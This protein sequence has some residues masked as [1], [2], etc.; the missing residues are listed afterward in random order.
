MKKMSRV[1]KFLFILNF[2]VACLLLL[3]GA[4]VFFSSQV[5]FFCT[6]LI[7]FLSHK[8]FEDRLESEI[9][10]GK[11][12]DI[13]EFEENLDAKD[14]NLPKTNFTLT[15]FSP[16]KIFAYILFFLL[17]YLLLNLELFSPLGIIVGV[18]IVQLGSFI[19]GAIFE[20]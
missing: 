12:D 10:S 4:A 8:S 2:A 14:K 18:A 3:V 11:Y 16:F 20:K 9:L 15:L 5:G 6:L 19:Y 17:M 13:E 7:V 1:Y